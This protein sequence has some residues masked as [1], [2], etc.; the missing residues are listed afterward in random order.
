MEKLWQLMLILL[1]HWE[2]M[3]RLLAR[4]PDIH[5]AEMDDVKAKGPASSRSPGG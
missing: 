3:S 1:I 2:D 5:W 4:V